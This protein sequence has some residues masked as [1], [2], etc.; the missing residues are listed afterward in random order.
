MTRKLESS[1][2]MVPNICQTNETNELVASATAM[3]GSMRASVFNL[4]RMAFKLRFAGEHQLA[5]K[6]DLKII[7]LL[8]KKITRKILAKSHSET[9]LR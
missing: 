8:D 7:S 2:A 5:K 9:H 6:I 3:L 4:E 1:A